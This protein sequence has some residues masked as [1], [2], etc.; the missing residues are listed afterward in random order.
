LTADNEF[1]QTNLFEE[2]EAGEEVAGSAEGEEGK[3]EEKGEP[4]AA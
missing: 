1:E 4:S 3:E 2:G